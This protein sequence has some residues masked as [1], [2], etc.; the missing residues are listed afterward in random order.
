M[1]KR[2]KEL[3][4]QKYL[5]E[6]RLLNGKLAVIFGT[7]GATGSQVAREF[8]RDGA[9]MFLPG[10]HLSLVESVA[11]E[12][13]TSHRRDEAAEVE[14][15][16]ERVVTAYRDNVVQLSGHYI[17]EERPDFLVNELVKFFNQ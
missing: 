9:T 11:K 14:V 4:I 2:D 13:H 17:A 6:N 10:R 3:R 7:G 1:T 15:L 5:S 8:S 16:S 12:I